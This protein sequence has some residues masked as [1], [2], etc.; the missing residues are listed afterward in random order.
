MEFKDKRTLLLN[1]LQKLYKHRTSKKFKKDELYLN[2]PYSSS[3]QKTKKKFENKQTL[4]EV[5]E[6]SQK[7]TPERMPKS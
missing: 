4:E 6:K 2:S 7:K 3:S 5:P 1:T